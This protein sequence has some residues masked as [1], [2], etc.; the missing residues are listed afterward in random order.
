MSM[1]FSFIKRYQKSRELD[2]TQFRQWC[3]SAEILEQDAHGLKV[4]RLESGDILKIFRVKRLISS[5]RLYSYAR[6]FCRNA[7]RLAEL[8]IPTVTVKQLYHFSDSTNTAVLYAP[9]QGKTFYDLLR[10]NQLNESCLMQLGNFVA[11]LHD[12]GIYFRS[13]HFGNV[14]LTDDKKLGLIDIADMR[15]FTRGLGTSRRLRNFRQFDR[16]KQGTLLLDSEEKKMM[17]RGYFETS[18]ISSGG[19]FYQKLNTVIDG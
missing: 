8:N 4:L 12:L 9:L 10:A 14:V 17:L 5:A 11:T 2:E 18:K 15:F 3:A 1:G 13:L 19:T 7:N 6:R 16:A